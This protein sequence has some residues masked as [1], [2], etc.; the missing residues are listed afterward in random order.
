MHIFTLF[1]HEKTG[2]HPTDSDQELKVLTLKRL[3]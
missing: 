3:E 2:F 1:A